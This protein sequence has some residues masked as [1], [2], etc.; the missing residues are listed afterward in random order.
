MV[1]VPFAIVPPLPGRVASSSPSGPH[2]FRP[3]LSPAPTAFPLHLAAIIITIIL[4]VVLLLLGFAFREG[5]RRPLLALACVV[6][7]RVGMRCSPP[8][9]SIAA[10]SGG[11]TMRSDAVAQVLQ[12][13]EGRDGKSTPV[14][15]LVA[16]R[17]ICRGERLCV[18]PETHILHGASATQLL[19][20]A[21]AEQWLP[22]YAAVQRCL[23]TVVGEPSIMSTRD[24]LLLLLAVHVLRRGRLRHPLTAWAACLPP[25]VPPMGALL[26]QSS[27][28]SRGGGGLRTA[29][30]TP[31]HRRADGGF[32]PW[33]RG[34]S[35]RC[36]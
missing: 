18:V 32:A 34:R 9:R 31:S 26:Q 13:R 7:R 29:A 20:R 25:R 17:V 22:S 35:R 12:R 6:P 21:A 23:A 16:T 5:S 19:Q 2:P 36:H 3:T 4:V 14:R 11:L 33:R 27:A 15:C 10:W 30:A 1:F 28:A 8:V 24:A